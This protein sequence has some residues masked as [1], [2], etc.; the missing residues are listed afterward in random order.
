[1]QISLRELIGLKNPSLASALPGV[2]IRVLERLLHVREL[3]GILK[4]GRFLRGLDFVRHVL[5]YFEVNISVRGAE[6]LAGLERPVVVSNHPLG[7]M[8]GMALLHCM[9]EFYPE[10][11]LMVNDFLMAI[12]NLSELFVPV[13]KL[14][15]NRRYRDEYRALYASKA[16]ILHF[17]AGLC[18]R[19]R[20]GRIK[21]LRWNRS[22]VRMARLAK[23]PIVPAFFE[24]RNRP[25][26]YTVARL[27]RHMGIGFNVEMLLL[28][29]EMF[30]QRGKN[31]RMI[32]GDPVFPRELSEKSPDYWNREIRLRVY[33]ME[34]NLS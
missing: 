3:N 14:G 19:K 31:L 18:S 17:P 23:R 24:G 13:S 4:N 22:Y 21:D 11:R 20:G 29:D 6:K 7:G 10:V 27:R 25:L 33:A 15:S 32:I 9:G 5:E 34:R 16:P 8:D 30:H 12:P 28:V 26:F 1:M 2:L